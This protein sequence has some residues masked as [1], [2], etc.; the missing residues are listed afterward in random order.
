MVRLEF[1]QLGYQVMSQF[2][3]DVFRIAKLVDTVL[4]KLNVKPILSKIIPPTWV[5]KGEIEEMFPKQQF[6]HYKSTS[7]DISR[8]P[9][10]VL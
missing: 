6:T 4:I 10:A 9:I 8:F 2:I 5:L 7:P 1:A 3:F